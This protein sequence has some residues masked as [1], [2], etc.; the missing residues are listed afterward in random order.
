M[1]TLRWCRACWWRRKKP[2]TQRREQNIP[3]VSGTVTLKLN[4]SGATVDVKKNGTVE[5][6]NLPSYPT[7]PRVWDASCWRRWLYGK[8]HVQKLLSIRR[9][10]SSRVRREWVDAHPRDG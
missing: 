10:F 1:C 4:S 3:G 5:V 2:G 8:G 9:E 6:G 7:G